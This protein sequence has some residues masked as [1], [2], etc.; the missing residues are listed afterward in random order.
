[1]VATRNLEMNSP[2]ETF[3]PHEWV[4]WIYSAG[5]FSPGIGPRG[6]GWERYKSSLKYALIRSL[7]WHM[8]IATILIKQ[9][10]STAIIMI[11]GS[12]LTMDHSHGWSIGLKNE[13]V[14]FLD[15][16]FYCSRQ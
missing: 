15:R 1:M 11:R 16:D 13:K 8:E 3:T 6:N 12:H 9:I 14:V 10:Y 4:R 2:D 7:L 5:V